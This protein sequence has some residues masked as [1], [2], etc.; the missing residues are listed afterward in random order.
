[1]GKLRPRED[2]EL[3]PGHTASKWE[4]RDSDPGGLT[5]GPVPITL[6]GGER[7]PGHDGR[8]ERERR[9]PG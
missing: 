8:D 6:M 7:F 3:V 2:E 9:W 5:G 4:C 1:M